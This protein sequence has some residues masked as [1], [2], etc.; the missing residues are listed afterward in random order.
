M[1][2][3]RL[4]L[5]VR[6]TAFGAVFFTVA[7]AV[8]VLSVALRLSQADAQNANTD[9]ATKVPIRIFIGHSFSGPRKNKAPS[10]KLC[11]V[12]P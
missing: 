5:S 11:S 9:T 3:L 12:N 2:R 1:L 8:P 10:V 4:K 7:V 6:T